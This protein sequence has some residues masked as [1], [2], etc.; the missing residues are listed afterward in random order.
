MRYRDDTDRACPHCDG[1]RLFIDNHPGQP[2]VT[3]CICVVHDDEPERFPSKD[4]LID[5]AMAALAA[6]A[7][8]TLQDYRAQLYAAAMGWRS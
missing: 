2:S 7:G 8:V 4:A 3:W 6:A 5:D 1:K